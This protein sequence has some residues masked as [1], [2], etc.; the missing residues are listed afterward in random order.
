MGSIE[1]VDDY[2]KVAARV[3]QKVLNS[4][5]EKWRLKNNVKDSWDG[6]AVAFIPT[7]GIL[8]ER[9]LDITENTATEL[10]RKIHAGQLSALE[11]TEAF[12]ARAAVAHQLVNCLTDFF[13]K[14]AI[15]YAKSLDDEFARTGKTVGPLHGMPMAVKDM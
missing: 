4:I 11:T 13:P 7:C 5:P 14:E 12:C 8:T 10:L 2:R 3:Q 9:Q 1:G 15:A 6:N